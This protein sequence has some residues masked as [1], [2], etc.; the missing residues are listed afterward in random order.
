MET[1]KE[2]CTCK[3]FTAYYTKGYTCYL[4]ENCGECFQTQQVMKKH[5]G[6]P[7][8]RYKLPVEREVKAGHILN[9]LEDTLLK[10]SCIYEYIEDNIKK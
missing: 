8:W 5:D 7:L 4:R 3:Y 2:C 10:I 9:A 1:K 6:C